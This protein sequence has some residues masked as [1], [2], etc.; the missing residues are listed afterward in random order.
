M[1]DARS[2]LVVGRTAV[3]LIKSLPT[4]LGVLLLRAHNTLLRLFTPPHPGSTYFGAQILCDPNDLIQRSILNF[5]VWEPNISYWIGRILRAGDVCIDV[6]ANIGYDTLLASSVVG[7]AGKVVAIE[8]APRI[9]SLL[10]HNV[11][12]NRATNVRLVNAAVSDRRQTLTLYSGGVRNIGATTTLAS[13]GFP[14]ETTVE[15]WGL[16]Q[17]LSPDE[18]ARAK[19]IKIDVE[20]GELAVLRGLL[21]QVSRFPNEIVVIVEASWHEQPADWDSVF[22]QFVAAGFMA[23]EIENRYTLEWYLNW[24]TPCALKRLFACPKAQTDLLWSRQPIA[25][26]TEPRAPGVP[27]RPP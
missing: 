25:D 4:P 26:L 5:G 11:R 22:E 19:L 2:N 18:L 6:G 20:G 16:A 24:R 27:A 12:I 15:A 9:F 1:D 7:A 13:R 14:I 21:A 8:A 3:D 17:L 10:E 23:Y